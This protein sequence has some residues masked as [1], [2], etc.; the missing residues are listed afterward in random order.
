MRRYVSAIALGGL[1]VSLAYYGSLQQ[2]PVSIVSPAVALPASGAEALSSTFRQVGRA[3]WYRGSRKLFTANGEHFDARRLTAAH[4]TLP[5]NTKI[6]VT[7]LENSRSVVLRVNDRGPY[8]RGRVIDLTSAA[9]NLLDMKH[10]GV[11]R[12]LIEV[13]PDDAAGDEKVADSR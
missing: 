8:I 13:I 1:V 4:R 9:A 5:F 6:R 11:A 3:S 10:D 2:P 7:N 12:V